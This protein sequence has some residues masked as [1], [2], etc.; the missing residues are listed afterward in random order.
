MYGQLILDKDTK[1]T[2]W[3]KDNLFS[4]WYW[5]NCIHLQKN[6]IGPLSYTNHK[7]QLK[8]INGLNVRPETIFLSIF[9]SRLYNWQQDTVAQFYP[10]SRYKSPTMCNKLCLTEE[11]T[12]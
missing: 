4:K 8:M 2:Q 3:K 7:N 6:E 11:N 10:I 5:K 9:K 12:S 1:N